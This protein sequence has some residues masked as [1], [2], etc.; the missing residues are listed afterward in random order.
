MVHNSLT[1]ILYSFA[2]FL[3]FHLS[4]FAQELDS[5]ATKKGWSIGALPALGYDS[6]LGLLYG[7]LVNFH[8]FGDGSRY[9]N[10]D[11]SIYMLLSAYTRGGMDAIIN[12]DSYT[13][14]PNKHL[15]AWFSYGRNRTYP[16][17]G[18]NGKQTIYEPDFIDQDYQHFI[19]QVYYAMDLE[20]I[21]ADIILQDKIGTTPFNWL[22]SLDL[23]YYN[24]RPVDV[25]HL[26]NR[27]DE[28]DQIRDTATLF[29][30][31]VDWGLI[32][33]EERNGGLD[34]S[35][36]MGLVYDTRDRIT[37]P[38]KGVWTELLTRVGPEFLGNYN[39]FLKVS[40]I[41]RQYFTLIDEKLSFAYRL[42]YEGAFGDTPFYSR[43]YMTASN[44][45]EGVGG[46]TTVM[47]ILMNR[48]VA[49]QNAFGNLELRWKAARFRL[50]GQNFYVGFNTFL[51]VGYILQGY[52]LDLSAIS[53]A[54]R[55]VSFDDDFQELI[56]TAGLGLK[57]VMNENFVVSADYARS[58]DE[59]YGTSG[60]YVRIGYLF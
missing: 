58:F 11:H 45:F 44:Y 48:V 40:L 18:F 33:Q 21:K 16:F 54:D 31:Y 14:I 35:V 23:G 43:H 17:Y 26:N 5:A 53:D 9:P 19:T 59:N 56:S 25:T 47:G 13:L 46:A 7:G 60:L 1:K 55:E 36:K 38:M 49:K 8:D 28:G 3:F 20:Q 51:D 57:L 41:H 52:D 42:W 12:L 24:V 30:N 32:N 39:S 6:N 34:F 50:I 4:G 27:N 29:Q 37:N 22:L 15:T 10:Y 2:G